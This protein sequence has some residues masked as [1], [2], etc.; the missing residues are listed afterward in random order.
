MAGRVPNTE[1][2][3]LVLFSRPGYRLRCPLLPV[4]R[5]RLVLKQVG[6]PRLLQRVL[7]RRQLR[8]AFSFS[9]SL[10]S[11][12]LVVMITRSASFSSISLAS[13]G[14]QDDIWTT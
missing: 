6:R 9:F 14:P 11:R 5:V 1:K 10:L 7:Q 3:H 8:L 4:H 13:G 12:H 2:D